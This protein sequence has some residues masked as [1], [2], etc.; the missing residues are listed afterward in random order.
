LLK[1]GVV[2]PLK[3]TASG[4][5]IPMKKKVYSAIEVSAIDLQQVTAGRTDQDASVGIDTGKLELYIVV[6]WGER[7]FQRPWRVGNP[8]EIAQAVRLLQELSQGRAMRIGMEPSGTYGEAMRYALHRAKLEL[9][10]VSPKASHDY[11]EIFD[12][13]P[14]QHD[15]K[16]AAVV[17][18]LV[19]IGKCRSWT[20]R[21]PEL[22]EQQLRYEVERMDLAKRRLIAASGRLEA[23]LARFWPEATRI[24]KLT[25][26]TLLRALAQ[27]GSP[28]AL[29]QDD[30]ALVTLRGY[31][32]G[33]VPEHRLQ[34]LLA[35]ASRGVSPEPAEP[36]RQW[37]QELAG[38]ML[39]CLRIL[40]EARSQLSEVT[41]DQAVLQRQAKAVGL[42]TACVMWA[43]LGD[44]RLY[45]NAWAYQKALGLNLK[46]RSSGKYKG[47]LKL[48]KRGSARV[49][50]WAFFSALRWCQHDAIW[51]WYQQ[52]K[53]KDGDLGAGKAQVALL[54]KLVR[55]SW[56][57][58]VDE[59]ARFDIK[60]LLGATRK[61]G[62]APDP[63][64]RQDGLRPAVK[65]QPPA[66]AATAALA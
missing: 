63:T 1:V 29:V 34:A 42:A 12:G 51:S 53:C 27:Y 43:D 11:A 20:Y 65:D 47:K 36:Q 66:A 22:W 24:V 58:A 4:E 30:Q 26:R 49:R 61:R 45:S 25:G 23:E 21:E 35:S 14:S 19:A 13:V 3:I 37:I 6:R 40:A 52:K 7:D 44:P 38:E 31:G 60:R 64:P 55:A 56:R 59:T 10:R 48:A 16:D 18:E 39:G 46:E 62:V 28:Q 8:S 33:Q 50:R 15:G 54:R 9:Q 17:A 5:V 2:P 57:V 32:R 41:R